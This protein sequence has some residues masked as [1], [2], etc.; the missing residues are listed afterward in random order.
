MLNDCIN[1]LKK[2]TF[3]GSIEIIVAEGGTIAQARNKGIQFAKGEMVA[4]IDSDCLA[5]REWLQTMKKHLKKLLCLEI[6][7]GKKS[8]P[9]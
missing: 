2:L 1:S 4:F 9:T 5:P 3:S 8:T 6:T 7:A